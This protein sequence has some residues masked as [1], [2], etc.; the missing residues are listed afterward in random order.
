MSISI[1][2]KE[3][4]IDIEEAENLLFS[5]YTQFKLREIGI[6]EEIIKII[7]L[8]CELENVKSL[9]PH[10]LTDSI[11]EIFDLSLRKLKELPNA[12]I[13]SKKWID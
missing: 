11:D 7:N 8:G 12:N 9:I 1:A 5:P 10:A 4:A 6:E 2:L 13:P 3:G